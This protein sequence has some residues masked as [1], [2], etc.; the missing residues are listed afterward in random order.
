MLPFART[1]H[2]AYCTRESHLAAPGLLHSAC[3]QPALKRV[4]IKRDH[5]AKRR[6][7]QLL[8]GLFCGL[9]VDEGGARRTSES[10]RST[11][12]HAQMSWKLQ[13]DTCTHLTGIFSRARLRDRRAGSGPPCGPPPA[14]SCSMQLLSLQTY[15]QRHTSMLMKNQ[16]CV[17]HASASIQINARPHQPH[18]AHQSC[19][20]TALP[21][22]RSPT[23]RRPCYKG[24]RSSAN[25][26]A[27]GNTLINLYEWNVNGTLIDFP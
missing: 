1:L 26:V 24:R 11:S 22:A 19:T 27:P 9:G 4:C 21:L 8:S 12:T 13:H 2:V 20:R 6:I 23:R 18:H 3:L 25:R 17:C 14:R 5:M 16:Q 15:A 10:S 7:N